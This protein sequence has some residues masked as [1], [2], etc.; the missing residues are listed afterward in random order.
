MNPRVSIVLPAYYSDAT[1]AGCLE[2]IEQQSFRDF[3]VI[4]VNSSPEPRTGETVRTRFPRVTFHQHATRLYPHAARNVGVGLATGEL[5]VFTDPDCIASP[6]WLKVLVESSRNWPIVQGS[7]DHAGK[8][9]RERGVHLCKRVSLLKRIPTYQPWI[10]SSI[11][12]AY[13]R[14][15]WLAS[16][17]LDGD[18][19]CG[20]ALLGW[21]AA[22]AGFEARF[23]PRAVV[24]NSHD[25]TVGGLVRQR[26]ARGREFARARADYEMWSRWRAGF[27]AIAF[28]LLVLTVL[29]RS[30]RQAALGGWGLDFVTTFPIQVAGHASWILGETGYYAARAV[31]PR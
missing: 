20:D 1:I 21:R 14:E 28:P 17:P 24:E 26:Y 7:V 3:E 11:N 5:I 31:A 15:A 12:A 18:L 8:G 10:V 25:E 30:A 2:A 29:W 13:T 16:G 19:F 27:F 23:E 22:D 6:D 4:V 9:W